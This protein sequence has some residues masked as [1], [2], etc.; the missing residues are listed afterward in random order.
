MKMQRTRWIPAAVAVLAAVASGACSSATPT[1]TPGVDRL[2]EYILRQKGPEVEAYLGYRFAS[3]SIASDWLILE[4]ALTSPNGQSADVKRAN[5]HVRTPDG[6]KVPL[7]TQEEFGKDYGGLRSTLQRAY[8]ARDPMDYFSPSRVDCGLNF[9]TSPGGG[10]VFD[11]LSLN[12]RR[13]CQGQLFFK[14]PGGIQKGRWT[15]D[16]DLDE[17][18][19]RIPFTL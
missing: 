19:I 5:V 3:Q 9:F 16:I 1:D 18:E 8:V 6:T 15:F 7:A 2:G 10:V 12:D 17:S 4:V 14:V 11:E 13:G